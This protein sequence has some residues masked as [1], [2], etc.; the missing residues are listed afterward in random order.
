M[1]S[2]R[3]KQIIIS[4]L[5]SVVIFSSTV[6]AQDVAKAD[7]V[8]WL[9][10]VLKTNGGGI[11]PDVALYVSE[12]LEDIGIDVTIVIEEWS[13]FDH[14]IRYTHDFDLAIASITGLGETPDFYH[15][16]SGN[17]LAN[18]FGIRNDIPYG[19]INEEM[20]LEGIKIMDPEE[21]QQL[22]YD[23]Q[24]LMNDKIIPIVPLFAAYSYLTTWSNTQGFNERWGF[25]DSLPYMSFDGLHEGQ[26]ST[27][28]FNI[29]A[30][31]DFLNPLYYHLLSGDNKFILELLHESM[32]Q[33]SPDQ[34]QVKTG[35]INDWIKIDDNHFKFFIRDNVYWNP[36]Y[37]CTS[38]DYLSPPLSSI[39]EGELMLGLKNGEFSNGTN[40]KVTAKD[41]VFTLLAI[42]NPLISYIPGFMQFISD[43]YVDPSD[44]LAFHIHIDNNPE[45]PELETNAEVWRRLTE[46]IMPEFFLNST[47]PMVSETLGGVQTVGLYPEMLDTP[48]WLI[49]LTSAFSCGKFM[50]DYHDPGNITVFQ[51]SPYWFGVGAIDGATDLEPFVQT[52]NVHAISDE[53][54]EF[55]LFKNG[56]LDFAVLNKFPEDRRVMEEDPR[57]NVVKVLGDN[58]HFVGFNL[59]RPF[60]GGA[61]NYV[62]NQEEGKKDYTLAC[63]LRKA[64]SY[65]IDSV[66]I[67]DDL[68]YGENLLA[69]STM[70]PFTSYYYC[71]DV[72]KYPR[73]LCLAN[74]WLPKKDY[75]PDITVTAKNHDKLGKDI[76]VTA[77][78]KNQNIVSSMLN[79]QVNDALWSNETMT[80][81][82]EN[83]YEY[84]I[85]K[86]FDEGDSVKFFMQLQNSNG[87]TYNSQNYSFIVGTENPILK[88]SFQKSTAIFSSLLL[89]ALVLGRIRKRRIVD[90]NL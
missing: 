58:I 53:S 14:T 52:L 59:R 84:N 12:Y 73:D 19:D 1:A 44:E 28:E 71:D 23:W 76:I 41:A 89:I 26:T 5:L 61:S 34:I 77:E 35:L 15:V 65:A 82:A 56:S 64:I 17:G 88:T 45:T 79:Y 68:Y 78:Y 36:S 80:N 51:R 48:Q 69:N 49:Y 83:T 18:Y 70:Y 4:F 37:D 38:R 57:Y 40:Q 6:N 13:V 63:S 20:L 43:I 39:P 30:Y 22:Y 3:R 66:E 16:F 42:G 54:I 62:F 8:I 85:G 29:A 55:A 87:L 27:S 74:D 25:L 7:S 86:D 47:N 67:N 72:V 9:N 46:R 33:W 21:R 10:L 32:I 11:R 90:R 2:N 81:E 24:K 60:I 50:L 31:W 75:F